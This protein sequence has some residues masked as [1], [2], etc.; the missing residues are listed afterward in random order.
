MP[1]VSN[2][3][4]AFPKV[5]GVLT[6]YSSM[7]LEIAGLYGAK[8]MLLIDVQSIDYSDKVDMRF[9]WLSSSFP[10]ARH[11]RRVESQGS[12]ELGLE[13]HRHVVAAL[14]S[15]GNGGFS[16]VSF[17]INVLY[18]LAPSGAVLVDILHGCRFMGDGQRN[19]VGGK[20]LSTTCHLSVNWIEW[21][22]PNSSS[23]GSV[24]VAA[25]PG[26]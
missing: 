9:H 14:V 23:G 3:Q 19:V 1:V 17:N 22:A 16:D 2:N 18:Q 12:I 6:S 25:G 4:L 10:V 11:G 8:P 7:S 13:T 24:I 26:Q 21:G 5:N 20:H 15:Q